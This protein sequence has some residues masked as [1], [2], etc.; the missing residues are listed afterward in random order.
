M[1]WGGGGIGEGICNLGFGLS[2]F[3]SNATAEVRCQWQRVFAVFNEC[4]K[5]VS[6]DCVPLIQLRLTEPKGFKSKIVK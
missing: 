5:A 1:D 3:L 4:Y 2:V 6:I